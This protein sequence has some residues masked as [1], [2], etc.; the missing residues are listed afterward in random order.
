MSDL[1]SLRAEAHRAHEAKIGRMGLHRA[2]GGGVGDEAEDRAMVTSAVHQHDK[3]K[4]KGQGLTNLKFRDGGHVEGAKG[5]D[6]HDRPHR[7]RGGST[8]AKHKGAHVNVIVAPQ[9][10]GGGPPMAVPV[11]AAGGMPPRPPGA[12]MAPPPPP[13]MMPPGGAPGGPPMGPPGMPMQPHKRGGR[14]RKAYADGGIIMAPA[15]APAMMAPGAAPIPTGMPPMGAGGPGGWMPPP[16]GAGPGPPPPGSAPAMPP[17]GAVPPPGGP[18]PMPSGPPPMP[19]MG[20]GGPGAPPMMAPG[21]RKAGGRVTF[22]NK[23]PA[24]AT[25]LGEVGGGGGLGRLAKIKEYGAEA[26]KGEGKNRGG[27]V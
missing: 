27:R 13:P 10:G 3:Q 15:G 16:P 18:P 14:V 7:A 21:M 2:A 19:P 24:P 26:D 5:A 23:K 9:G 22:E 4:H 20:A 6:R 25:H 12:G 8:N 17:P 11:P 1:R